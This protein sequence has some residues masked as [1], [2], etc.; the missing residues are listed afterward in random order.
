MDGYYYNYADGPA[1]APAAC[2]L[3]SSTNWLVTQELAVNLPNV[4]FTA[5]PYI[6]VPMTPVGQQFCPNSALGLTIKIS[7]QNYEEETYT[8]GK[9]YVKEF[10]FT[11][12]V[13]VD[14]ATI[15]LSP[16]V[17]GVHQ[18]T[19]FVPCYA[20][21]MPGDSADCTT[22]VNYAI[23]STYADLTGYTSTVS[24]L[25]LQTWAS[26]AV[27]WKLINETTQSWT[28]NRQSVL[29]PGGSG[30]LPNVWVVNR[31][32]IGTDN[33]PIVLPTDTSHAAVR[34]IIYA[35][36]QLDGRSYYI[37]TQDASQLLAPDAPAY[38]QLREI[39]TDLFVPWQ[40]IVKAPFSNL[41]GVTVTIAPYDQYV[42]RNTLNIASQHGQVVTWS[43][44]PLGDTKRPLDTGKLAA[45]QSASIPKLIHGKPEFAID[46]DTFTVSV[47]LVTGATPTSG[48]VPKPI[49]TDPPVLLTLAG[50]FTDEACYPDPVVD[51][52]TGLTL[53][54]NP[55]DVLPG[56]VVLS[57]PCDALNAPAAG[58][59]Y[60][61]ANVGIEPAFEMA[62]TNTMPFDLY[63]SL[64]FTGDEADINTR[65]ALKYDPAGCYNNAVPADGTL[66][67]V[68]PCAQQL[69]KKNTT[70]IVIVFPEVIVGAIA[71]GCD[72][73]LAMYYG[74]PTS[75][76]LLVDH[77]DEVAQS[78]GLIIEPL[79][80]VNEPVPPKSCSAA[81]APAGAAVLPM[82]MTIVNTNGQWTTFIAPGPVFRVITDFAGTAFVYPSS[83]YASP[84]LSVGPFE[85]VYFAA[86]LNNA[87][88]FQVPSAGGAPSDDPYRFG[89]YITFAVP[90]S[91]II[92][93]GSERPNDRP[94]F[95]TYALLELSNV[96][97]AVVGTQFGEPAI[98][99]LTLSLGQDQ[100]PKP[101]PT[102]TQYLK[103]VCGQPGFTDCNPIFSESQTTCL[104]QFSKVFGVPCRDACTQGQRDP[105]T[106]VACDQLVN[107]WCQ[108]DGPNFNSP[109]CSCVNRVS[110]T[111]TIPI[112]DGD[113]SYKDF[114]GEFES[115][116]P[117]GALPDVL[118]D[119]GC[120]W[121]T[122]SAA[123]GL[124]KSSDYGTCPSIVQNCFAAISNVD[125]FNS[126]VTLVV[127]NNCTA[128]SA[129]GNVPSGPPAPVAQ[130]SN[131]I[132]LSTSWL[133]PTVIGTVI[134]I[135]VIA[136][137][138][139]LLQ[140]CKQ[141]K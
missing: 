8:N 88:V 44:N 97:K 29:P 134:L 48:G 73:Y 137:F 23:V 70:N 16:S 91:E 107:Q 109:E 22:A 98:Y 57:G 51:P 60:G 35:T 122:C 71:Y 13:D 129:G 75:P 89:S 138:A 127:K 140:R 93:A 132:Q 94:H 81:A 50:C 133:L 96:Q 32:R 55:P 52:A 64:A 58:R 42:F 26:S 82:Y 118:R 110:S 106:L 125:I 53:T 130:K 37:P 17:N 56:E 112:L 63:V 121:P 45:G 14:R 77:P 69:V 95:G 66:P 76:I 9:T 85:P 41:Y 90:V 38:W 10:N 99:T 131:K 24:Y 103:D 34:N 119:I 100:I 86:A 5:T 83:S 115:L 79:G 87:I 20:T 18:N 116:Y 59:Y 46:P 6:D 4:R 104:G 19:T 128:N 31:K 12:E 67:A 117:G 36:F 78:I 120:W 7:L 111:H 101:T 62:I 80:S 25:P 39:G 92:K 11:K 126:D 1:G 139:V 28:V 43:A 68:V 74:P 102:I 21:T 54:F 84:G 135:A 33:W 27:G 123:G 114:I 113:Y 105:Q 15:M 3:E 47:P 141:G 72:A 40:V 49:I 108:R 61:C 124:R 2:G 136:G 30:F 65:I